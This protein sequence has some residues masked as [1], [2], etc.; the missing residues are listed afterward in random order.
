M[1]LRALQDSRGTQ[2]G[3]KK[4][5]PVLA[6]CVAALLCTGLIVPTQAQATDV[7]LIGGGSGVHDSYASF[8]DSVRWKRSVLS[9]QDVNLT[10]LFNDGNLTEPDINFVGDDSSH[11]QTHALSRVFGNADWQKMRYRNHG[12]N[13]V[14]AGTSIKELES[15]ITANLASKSADEILIVHT[16][17]GGFTGGSADNASLKLWNDSRLTA[18]QL[19]SWIQQSNTP[20]RFVF[21]QSHSGGFHRLAYENSSQ[22]LKLATQIHCG[23]TSTSAYQRAETDMTTPGTTDYRDYASYFFSA[24]SGFEYDGEII[25]RFSDMDEDGQTSLREAHLFA[26]LEGRS[27]DLPL[28]T[29]EDYLLRWQPWYLRWQP[30]AKTLPNNEYT[31]IFRDIASQ[32]DI[33]LTTNV[34][35]ELRK[36]IRQLSLN[37]KE[38]DQLHREQ[39]TAIALL[40]AKLQSEAFAQWPQLNAPYTSGFATLVRLGKLPEI[41]AFLESRQ[42]AYSELVALMESAVNTQTSSLNNRR[43]A[44]QYAKLIRLRHLALLKGQL[45]DNGSSEQINDYRAL[46]SC[47]EAPLK[48]A[49]AQVRLSEDSSQ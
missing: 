32:L 45:Y 48:P 36:R 23:F 10:T 31:R 28:S 21:S 12:L 43:E 7:I 16:G 9:E 37:R 22:G 18:K 8:E 17:R 30:A 44:S 34:A 47:E 14:D 25:S 27:I 19:H 13:N 46:V 49:Q 41:N 20:V 4:T 38:L 2:S 5:A 35:R 24:L 15:T 39:T 1:N 42:P 6:A 3:R 26:L 33:P 40:Q 11:R 29:S